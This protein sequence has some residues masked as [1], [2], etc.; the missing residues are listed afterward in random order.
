MGTS[1]RLKQMKIYIISFILLITFQYLFSQQIVHDIRFDL[2]QTDS[3]SSKEYVARDQVIFYP[4]Y[5]FNGYT[6]GKMIARIDPNQIFLNN[7]TPIN[8]IPNVDNVNVNTNENLSFIPGEINVSSTGSAVYTIP[9]ELPQGTNGMTPELSLTYNSQ[10]ANGLLGWGWNLNGLSSIFRT[11]KT[12]YFDNNIG[13]IEFNSNDRLVVD[14]ERLILQS[15][16]YFEPNST[17]AKEN[18]DFSNIKFLNNNDGFLLYTKDGI[19]IT[20]GQGSAKLIPVNYTIPYAWFISK[21]KDR[22]GNYIEYVY[23]NQWGNSNQ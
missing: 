22:N 7:P 15:G 8:Q 21:I 18:Y 1:K 4:G 5:Q 9:I 11:H 23:N 10:T 17:Y 20:Y 16:N 19:E 12:K 14:G 6:D 13:S 3:H 2:Y